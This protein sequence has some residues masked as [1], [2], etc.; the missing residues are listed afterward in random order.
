MFY[1]TRDLVKA[2]LKAVEQTGK[3]IAKSDDISVSMSEVKTEIKVTD[4]GKY[5]THHV[6]I[7]GLDPET[8]YSFL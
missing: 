8:E 7:K 2:E 3:N 6:E 5:Y 4:K 1:D